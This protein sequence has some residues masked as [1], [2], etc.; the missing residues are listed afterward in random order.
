M[1]NSHI[2]NGLGAR[3]EPG[4]QN[5]GF[6]WLLCVQGLLGRNL[7]LQFLPR[8]RLHVV[9]SPGLDR[10]PCEDGEI[11]GQPRGLGKGMVTIGQWGQKKPNSGS[12]SALGVF[13]FCR[14]FLVAGAALPTSHAA[15][16]FPQ[17]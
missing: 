10:R 2:C 3:K 14:E 9:Q 11:G 1:D 6:V 17:C 15:G 7:L 16:C 4:S 12:V 5:W 8:F 13:F